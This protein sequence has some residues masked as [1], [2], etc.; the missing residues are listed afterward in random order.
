M[1][2]S[3]TL[4]QRDFDQIRAYSNL[5]FSSKWRLI[6]TSRDRR[7][8]QGNQEGRKEKIKTFSIAQK[9]S[10]NYVDFLRQFLHDQTQ[11]DLSDLA[12]V[13]KSRVRHRSTH[14]KIRQQPG[15]RGDSRVQSLQN[16][17]KFTNLQLSQLSELF[18]DQIVSPSKGYLA[19]FLKDK[20]QQCIV[21]NKDQTH[22]FEY[23]SYQSKLSL[24][25]RLRNKNHTANILEISRMIN[26]K[27]V[28]GFAKKKITNEIL[29]QSS[30]DSQSRTK[31]QQILVT[32]E[33]DKESEDKHE[34]K[35]IQE[36]SMSISLSQDSDEEKYT[37]FTPKMSVEKTNETL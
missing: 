24:N 20:R 33:C 27:K 9:V 12:E 10:Q 36:A 30:N 11:E 29:F 1:S 21:M 8:F 16:P 23:L 19:Q 7:G 18:A 28:L 15:Q 14:L 35:T 31:F 2:Q 25:L 32:E 6:Q 22:S 37:D 3:L 17:V 34:T 13:L 4:N 26:L 5:D